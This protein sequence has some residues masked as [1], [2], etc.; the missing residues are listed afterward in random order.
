ML[1]IAYVSG[2]L[3]Q[4]PL[5]ELTT[6]PQSSGASCLQQLQLRAFNL[7]HSDVL[8]GTPASRSQLFPSAV[9]DPGF[10]IRGS[11]FRNSGQNHQYFVTLQQAYVYTLP[12]A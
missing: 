8:V 1:K 12:V 5:G 11:N 9:A 3:P 10:W 6:L 2:T 7:P 4:T